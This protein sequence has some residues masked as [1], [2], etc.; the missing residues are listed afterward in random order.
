[1]NP[2]DHAR[3]IFIDALHQAGRAGLTPEQ[4]LPVL[5]D[6]TASV[7]IMTGGEEALRLIVELMERRVEDWKAGRFP[8]RDAN[9]SPR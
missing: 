4:F 5:A 9:G 6:V 2:Y 8:S 3:D 1:M 7:A